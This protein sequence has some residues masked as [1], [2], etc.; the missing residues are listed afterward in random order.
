ML[1]M[2]QEIKQMYFWEH[3]TISEI[4]SALK[5]DPKIVIRIIREGPD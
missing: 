3:L 5:I 2:K 4:A 1:P